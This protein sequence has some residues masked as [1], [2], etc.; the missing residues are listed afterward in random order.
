MDKVFKNIDS[1]V[2]SFLKAMLHVDGRER[3]SAKELIQFEF[4]TSNMRIIKGLMREHEMRK[5]FEAQMHLQMQW[6]TEQLKQAV[7]TPTVNKTYDTAV[8]GRG[9]KPTTGNL[10]NTQIL[11]KKVKKCFMLLNF[12]D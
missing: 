11:V 1:S 4:I 8:L 6:M 5:D 12:L 2:V 10:L 9:L 7:R 3:K